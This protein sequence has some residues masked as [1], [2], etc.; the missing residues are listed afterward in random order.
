MDHVPVPRPGEPKKHPESACRALVS[1]TGPVAVDRLRVR[2][3]I[4]WGLATA[5]TPLGRL[6]FFTECLH[7]GRR[8]RIVAPIPHHDMAMGRRTIGHPDLDAAVWKSGNRWH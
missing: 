3:H 4:E 7:V 1:A 5:V 2:L 8:Y 6:P